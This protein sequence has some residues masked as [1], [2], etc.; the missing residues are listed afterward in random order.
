MD[1][2]EPAHQLYHAFLWSSGRCSD[3]ERQR[4]T[5]RQ[6]MRD[7]QTDREMKTNSLNSG[8]QTCNYYYYYLL[9]AFNPIN[10]T[11]SPQGFSLDLTQVEYNTKYVHYI[12]KHKTYKHN[13]KVSPFSIALVENGKQS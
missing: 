10:H 2:V 7:T 11:G 5:E 8:R 1:A 3:R 12:Y 13:P 4:G 6:R 9:K